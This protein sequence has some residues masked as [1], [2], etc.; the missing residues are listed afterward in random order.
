MIRR[1]EIVSRSKVND[2]HLFYLVLIYIV[3]NGTDYIL[4]MRILVFSFFVQSKN[5]LYYLLT[6]PVFPRSYMR[7]KR[8]VY[9]SQ[10]LLI[11]FSAFNVMN[12]T[13]QPSINVPFTSFFY[14]TCK[15]VGSNYSYFT[16]IIMKIG[17]T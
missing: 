3:E 6:L 17:R 11:R 13:F 14:V 12:K 9:L 10:R 2:M 5:K 15:K 8:F 16:F 7:F 1:S 4:F